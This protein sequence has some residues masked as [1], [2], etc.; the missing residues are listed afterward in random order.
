MNIFDT[1]PVESIQRLE[2]ALA[3]TFDEH[4]NPTGFFQRIDEFLQRMGADDVGAFCAFAEE[5]V[6]LLDGPVVGGHHKTV[7]VHVQY[8][9]LAHDGQA[10][11][12]DVGSADSHVVNFVSVTK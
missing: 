7:V 1:S 5:F 6:D 2:T 9:I 10:D 12:T 4:H 8:E 11:E 3:H